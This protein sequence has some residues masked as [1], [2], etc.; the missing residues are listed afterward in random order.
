MIMK[1]KG[2]RA[3]WCHAVVAVVVVVVVGDCSRT[4]DRMQMEPGVAGVLRS[5]VGLFLPSHLQAE[6]V[7]A[8]GCFCAS[9]RT[10]T[11]MG[12]D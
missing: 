9:S 8:H 11:R 6:A 4:P 5:G 10:R 7:V 2:A 12:R 1:R 3:G